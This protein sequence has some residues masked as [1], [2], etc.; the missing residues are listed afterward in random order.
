LIA[1]THYN[2]QVWGLLLFYLLGSY[3]RHFFLLVLTLRGLYGK[4]LFFLP[5]SIQVIWGG[6]TP[7]CRLGLDLLYIVSL[8]CTTSYLDIFPWGRAGF[9]N[10]KLGVVGHTYNPS[11]WE[12]RREFVRV[13]GQPEFPRETLSPNK[14][15][16]KQKKNKPNSYCVY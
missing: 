13:Q 6:F 4:H 7:G 3:A 16:N 14:Q 9:K 2:L 8:P 1:V 5:M 11:T 15:T 10:T 12:I